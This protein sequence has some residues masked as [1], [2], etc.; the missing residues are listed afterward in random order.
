[1]CFLFI[2]KMQRALIQ[3]CGGGSLSANKFTR[4][5]S[6]RSGGAATNPQSHCPNRCAGGVDV[7]SATG[8]ISFSRAS[9][10]SDAIYSIYRA[11]IYLYKFSDA[12]SK[13]NLFR[14][15]PISE[16]SGF[17]VAT[18]GLLVVLKL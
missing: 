13:S 5:R 8:F 7:Q 4:G 18:A 1:M 15:P 6:N 11:C 10:R 9:I 14:W 17:K 16:G 3:F 2:N 12:K